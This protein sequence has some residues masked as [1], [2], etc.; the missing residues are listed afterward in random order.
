MIYKKIFTSLIIIEFAAEVWSHVEIEAEDYF[1]PLEPV[2]NFC[3]MAEHCTHDFVKIC[4]QDSK[5][6]TRK[7]N[8]NCD[9]F[10]YNCD[11]K[12][13]YRHVPLNVCAY[14]DTMKKIK[15]EESDSD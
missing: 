3:Q 9:L 13:Q 8:D 14:I 12:G 10:E 5:G 15:E 7:F 2:V 4:G 1:F 11:Q 6:V